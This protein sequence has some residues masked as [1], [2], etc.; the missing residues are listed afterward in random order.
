MQSLPAR[1][2]DICANV[3]LMFL[4]QPLMFLNSLLRFLNSHEVT[5]VF[6][7]CSAARGPT[8]RMVSWLHLDGL[9]E[10]SSNSVRDL[11]KQSRKAESVCITGLGRYACVHS[12]KSGVQNT[13]ESDSVDPALQIWHTYTGLVKKS[14]R[15]VPVRLRQL[16]TSLTLNS[17][18]PRCHR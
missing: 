7:N 3:P 9:L 8:C 5:G 4:K 18:M 17:L 1:R 15:R 14:S 13:H 10:K 11:H 2:R 12:Y 16:S 6:H